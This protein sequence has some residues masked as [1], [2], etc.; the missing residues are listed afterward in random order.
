MIYPVDWDLFLPV[1]KDS[2][3]LVLMPRGVDYPVDRYRLTT[4]K[5][6]AA[7]V[8]AT[9]ESMQIWD[10]LRAVDLLTVEQPDLS[11]ISVYGRDGMGVLGLY[12][13]A[14]DERITRVILE[15][16]PGSHLRGPALLNVLRV[17]DIPEAAALVAP[18]EIVH[19]TPLPEAYDYTQSI[20]RL[21]GAEES[22]RASRELRHA[23]L[24]R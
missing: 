7:L 20:Y 3:V 9:L 8:G 24:G 5:R 14:L 17:T 1:V 10:V 22:F 4:L 16:P 15:N 23:L 11:S 6:T 12:A 2:I 19:L 21:L 13:A 18:R